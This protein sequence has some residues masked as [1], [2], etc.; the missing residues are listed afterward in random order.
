[1][2]LGRVGPICRLPRTSVTSRSLVRKS[3]PPCSEDAQGEWPP[4]RRTGRDK[5]NLPSAASSRSYCT[6]I[7]DTS[8]TMTT[9]AAPSAR[10]P[11]NTLKYSEF[12]SSSPPH[13]SR[14]AHIGRGRKPKL[15]RRQASPPPRCQP[16]LNSNQSFGSAQVERREAAQTR[17]RRAGSK[18]PRRQAPSSW[19]NHALMDAERPQA[20]E[21]IRVAEGVGFEPTR[22][23]PAYTRSRRAPSTTRPPLRR[24]RRNIA[25]VLPSATAA[26][27]LPQHLCEAAANGPN[28]TPEASPGLSIAR[29]DTYLTIAVLFWDMP[30][31]FS[32]AAWACP[33]VGQGA[34]ARGDHWICEGRA[35][36]GVL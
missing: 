11:R 1:M 17:A 15:R 13:R 18:A 9:L 6:A 12:I 31:L 29:R 25:S 14:T 26:A 35:L 23:L 8:A 30:I 10:M 28:A 3:P 33:H 4:A 5:L 34:A 2:P 24:K 7:L 27:R 22:R 36:G 32:S 20:R 16:K 21:P 19:R